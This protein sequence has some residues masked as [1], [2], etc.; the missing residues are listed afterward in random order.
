[1]YIHKH[2]C[3][4]MYIVYT[5]TYMYIH[6]YTAMHIHTTHHKYTYTHIALIVINTY[7]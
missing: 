5:Q 7:M 3:I 6:V 2:T 4:Y 1:M